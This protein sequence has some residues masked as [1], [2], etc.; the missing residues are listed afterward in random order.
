MQDTVAAAETDAG[1]FAAL[2]DIG[3]RL[4]AQARVQF[5]QRFQSQLAIR[6]GDDLAAA[7]DEE[8]IAGRRRLDRSDVLHHRIH[9][10]VGRHHARHAALAAQRLGKRHHQLARAGADVWRRDDGAAHFG[11]QLVPGARRGIVVG[12]ALAFLRK[13]GVLVGKADIRHVEGARLLGRLQGRQRI[14]RRGALLERSH[15]GLLGTQPFGNGLSMAVR[16]LQHLRVER[17]QGA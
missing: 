14:G 1:T 4:R 3:Q 16:Q 9:H 15:D 13:D 5:G 2:F 6:V 10:H 8:G 17:C 12:G 11:R 7:I